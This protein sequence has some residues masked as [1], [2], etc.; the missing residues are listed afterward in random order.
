MIEDNHNTMEFS[1]IHL[2]DVAVVGCRNAALGELFNVFRPQGVGVPDGFATTADS[3]RRFLI[4]PSLQ[5]KLQKAFEDLD[6]ENVEQ[7]SYA[8]NEARWALLET[9]LPAQFCDAVIQAHDLLN[10]RLGSAIDLVVRPSPM[11]DDLPEAFCSDAPARFLNVRGDS[12]LIEAVQSCFTSGFAMSAIRYRRRMGHDYLKVACSV[13][14]MPMIPSDKGSSGLILTFDPETGMRNVVTV[15]SSYGLGEPVVRGSVEPDQWRVTKPTTRC[16]ASDL[17][18]DGGH[19]RAVSEPTSADERLRFSLVDADVIQ[20]A[21]WACAIEDHFGNV[22]GLKQPMEIEWAKDGV[23]GQLYIVD[24]G[25]AILH[26]AGVRT[27]Y[28]KVYRRTD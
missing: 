10:R 28:N 1:Q 4:Q 23:L 2:A 3:Y 18:S 15:T 9:P 21:S 26:S 14:V 25:P 6:V 20:L 5:H 17:V 13:G 16:D 8:S 19:R 12:A 11:P 27:W 22:A 7:L 24:A